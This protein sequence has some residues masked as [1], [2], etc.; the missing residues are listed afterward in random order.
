M[1]PFLYSPPLS[2]PFTRPIQNI[3]YLCGNSKNPFHKECHGP[4]LHLHLL[5]SRPPLTQL[6]WAF[7]GLSHLPLK[8]TCSI[9]QSDKMLGTYFPVST[10]CLPLGPLPPPA[11]ED[12]PSL[13]RLGA[14]PPWG[15]RAPPS[16]SLWM[17]LQ[18]L[19]LSPD[20]HTFPV[21]VVNSPTLNPQWIMPSSLKYFLHG[22]SRI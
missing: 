16:S 7:C 21:C 6:R 2:L 17:P 11:P 8:E 15:Q 3:L 18:Q 20:H 12:C 5:C 9:N 10:S 19:P 22:A 1:W 4:R 14:A 13:S